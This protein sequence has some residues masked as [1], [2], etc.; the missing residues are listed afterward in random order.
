[1]S[2]KIHVL[3]SKLFLK[4]DSDRGRRFMA[5]ANTVVVAPDW[6]AG[7]LDYKM[8][9]KDGS[10]VDLTPPKPPAKAVVEEAA[11]EKAIAE[12]KAKEPVPEEKE[13]TDEDLEKAS[14]KAATTKA[15]PPKPKVLDL[16]PEATKE[17]TDEE[18]EAASQAV[19]RKSSLPQATKG[20]AG[21]R[22]R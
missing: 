10:I 18:L 1:M 15:V 17:P 3:R 5:P 16:K 2:I 14:V 20:G 19:A 22:A 4:Q 11:Q 9:L 13:P 21:L 12:V 7:T 8:G 6:V